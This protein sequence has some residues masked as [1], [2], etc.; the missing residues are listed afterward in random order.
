[1]DII[2]EPYTTEQQTKIETLEAR[3]RSLEAQILM[4]KE[5]E[6]NILNALPAL[7]L[8]ADYNEH[9]IFLNRSAQFFLG[10]PREESYNLVLKDVLPPDSLHLLRRKYFQLFKSNQPVFINELKI[11]N[12][13]GEEKFL[14]VAISKYYSN[15]EQIGFVGLGYLPSE[16]FDTTL[17][18][19]NKSL[20][21]FISLIAHDLRNPFNSLI[22]FSN[23]L[24]ENY[25]TYSDEK[26]KE[27]VQHL[28]TASSQGFQLLDNLLE[29]S[30]ITTGS[31]KPSP[32]VFKV[33]TVIENTIQ[34]LQATLLKKEIT[35]STTLIPDLFVNADPNMIQAAIRNILSNAI[36]FTHRNGHIE[37]KAYRSK[38][39]AIIDIKD[40]G[41]GM[42][43]N[44]IR[45]LF[46]IGQVVSS[47]GTEG[48]KGTGMGLL[49][50]K[51][52]IESNGGKITVQSS[53][54]KGST[55]RVRL[56]LA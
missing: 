25:D 31:I 23:L 44:V 48:E 16:F 20:L 47:K 18:E 35:L 7:V 22:G 45:N 40:N 9:L 6:L 43:S 49:L 21:K 50:C 24:L 34:L 54:G 4:L 56:P 8:V 51:E 12:A 41:V 11:L 55:F 30:R 15:F 33:D 17:E 38:N 29:W 2:Q 53:A 46:K 42:P 10:F 37:V 52:F 32:I 36:K 14:S 3:I 13:K 1:M 5:Q 27:Y 19:K 28:Y 26:R 39:F